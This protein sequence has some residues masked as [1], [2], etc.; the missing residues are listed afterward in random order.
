MPKL[1]PKELKLET[2]RV[3]ITLTEKKY[4]AFQARKHGFD[5]V[6]AYVLWCLRS[7]EIEPVF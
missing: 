5:N 3:K 7:H 2:L 4:I 6:S 1:K